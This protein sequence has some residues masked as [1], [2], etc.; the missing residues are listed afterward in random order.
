MAN[1]IQ[2]YVAEREIKCLL[3]F[4]RQSNLESILQ[5]GLVTRNTLVLEGHNNFND[6]YRLDGTDAV[7][8]SIGFPNYKMFFGLRQA[9]QGED[10]VVLAIHPAALWTLPC[11][12]CTTN[13]ASA[14]VTAIPL[15]QRRDLAALQLMYEDWGEKTRAMLGIQNQYPTNPQAEVLMLNGVPREY[16]FGVIVLNQ[17]KQQELKAK[18][19]NLDVRALAG[20]FRY[21]SDYAH[22]KQG[23]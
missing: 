10:W 21:R 12:F 20:Y 5:R 4:T 16:I 7:C 1:T 2:E 15:E 22:W 9:N 11:A 13:A 14:S 3:H 23:V 18:Y 17:A 8:L 6:Q 19:P